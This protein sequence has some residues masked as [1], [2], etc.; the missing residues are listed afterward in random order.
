MSDLFLLVVRNGA[1]DRCL[2]GRHHGDGPHSEFG[3]VD[4]GGSDADRA[5]DPALHQHHHLRR[6]LPRRRL[7]LPGDDPQVLL[8][9]RRHLPHRDHRR[10]RARGTARYPHC[11]LLIEFFCFGVVNVCL[12]F[13]C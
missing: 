11:T 7:L 13:T 4:R 12:Q 3:V 1:R 2:H 6:R 5:R 10:Q 9:R 8:G